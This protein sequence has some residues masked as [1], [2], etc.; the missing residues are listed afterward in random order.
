MY[1]PIAL[2]STDWHL[3]S[4]NLNTIKRLVAFQCQ[5]ANKYDLE[6]IICLGDVFDSRI[7]QRMDVF[8]AFFD[9]LE[10]CREYKIMLVCIPGNHDKTDYLSEMSFLRPFQTHEYLYL[11]EDYQVFPVG[12]YHFHFIPYFLEDEKYLEYL[13]KVEYK[14]DDIL[15]S[16]IAVRGSRN[17]DGETVDN[18]LTVD[19]FKGFV[20]VYF[21]HYHNYQ[22]VADGIYHLPAICQ[23][24]FG[25]DEKKGYT[26]I[27]SGREFQIIK[28]DTKKYE[29][30]RI[31]LGKYNDLYAIKKLL[32]DYDPQ[33]KHIRL[34]FSGAKNQIASINKNR[35]EEQGY[36]VETK[37]EAIAQSMT[38]VKN[39]SFTQYN[40]KHIVQLFGKFCDMKS[41]PFDE[42][43]TFLNLVFNQV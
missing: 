23:D 31:D 27:Y 6:Y 18:K 22:M 19:L 3:K 26:L 15:F 36:V 9:I 43:S 33:E 20:A 13:E 1:L 38:V 7:S 28:S 35:L 42:G 29:T 24:N 37:D 32:K 39:N 40:Q 17:N 5:L 2:V 14:G 10:I 30:V 41:V 25:E 16:H 4:T 8:N 21:G 34:V 12:K 11:I